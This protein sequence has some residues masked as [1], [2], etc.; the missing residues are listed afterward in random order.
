VAKPL[1]S[2]FISGGGYL[3][4]SNSAGQ[5]A[6]DAGRKSNFGFNVKYTKKG[7]NLKGNVNVLVRR[8]E[9]DGIV[10]VYQIKGNVMLSLAVQVDPGTAT[11]NGKASIQDITDPLNP[12]SIDGNATL[13]IDMDD[14]GEP[15]SEDL[16]GITVWKG[17][18]GLWFASKWDGT[19]TVQQTSMDNRS[20]VKI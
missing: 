16:I 12:I 20:F 5:I 8:L 3:V 1:A 2:N 18:G 4:L 17:N 14:N 11:F 13:Q 6:G 9:A 19:Q 10:H 15:G 7:T